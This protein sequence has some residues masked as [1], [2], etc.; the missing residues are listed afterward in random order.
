MS[1]FTFICFISKCLRFFIDPVL[2]IIFFRRKGHIS[3]TDNKILK[4]S[5][6]DL[7]SDIKR[8]KVGIFFYIIENKIKMEGSGILI[9]SIK[10][11]F[12]EGS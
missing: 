1:Y 4:L 8:Q 6:S 11:S 10:V 7:T 3:D 5:I 9:K 2:A 12:S